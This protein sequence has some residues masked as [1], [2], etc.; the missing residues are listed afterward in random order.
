MSLEA[1]VNQEQDQYISVLEFVNNLY[2]KARPQVPL[3]KIVGYLCSK[4]L[5]TDLALYEKHGYDYLLITPTLLVELETPTE[6]INS[7]YD[8]LDS[9]QIGISFSDK[10]MKAF[11]GFYF[12]FSEA[13]KLYSYLRSDDSDLEL[14]NAVASKAFSQI[15]SNAPPPP[16]HIKTASSFK[17]KTIGEVIKAQQHKD[18]ILPNDYQRITML[19]DYFTPR[20]AGCF[21]AGLHPNFNGS[22]DGLEMANSIINGGIKSGRLPIDDDGQINADNLKSF[23]YQKGWL[24]TGFNDDS[25]SSDKPITKIKEDLIEAKSKILDLTAKLEQA[26]LDSIILNSNGILEQIEQL[27]VEN[28]HLKEQQSKQEID[29][30]NK[31]AALESELKAASEALADNPAEADTLQGIAKYNANKAYII[32]TSQALAKYIWSMD[33]EKAIRTG[34]MV[35]QIRHVMH[36]VAPKLLPDDDAIRQWLSSIAPD[37]AKKGGKTP[38][39]APNEISLIMKK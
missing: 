21:I 14:T 4:N 19:Y 11:K 22:D 27:T 31:I 25:L 18:T 20:Q 13:S 10:D 12:K 6:V 28:K 8:Y 38:K 16:N 2:K 3:K 9:T 17:Q 32:S 30:Q 1:Y 7:L 35:Q 29:A 23:L 34:D 15:K 36:S 26:E 5:F 24:M 37:Y 33:T 39:D